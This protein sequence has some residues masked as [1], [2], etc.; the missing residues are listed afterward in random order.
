MYNHN[1]DNNHY[2]L[3]WWRHEVLKSHVLDQG[4]IITRVKNS[5]LDSHSKFYAFLGTLHIASDVVCDDVE[6]EY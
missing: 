2:F 6:I 5:K 1:D 4:H 3:F